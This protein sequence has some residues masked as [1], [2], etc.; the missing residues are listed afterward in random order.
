MNDK[1]RRTVLV[2]DDE[3]LVLKTFA[4]VFETSDIRVLSAASGEEALAI[5]LREPV[6]VV[7]SDHSMPGMSGVELLA[8]LKDH[9]PDTVRILMTGLTDHRMVVAAI[10]R[11]EA[12]RFVA[13]P[14]N[15]AELVA[16]ISE[17]LHHYEVLTSMRTGDEARYRSLAATIEL[18]DRYTRGHCDRV[19]DIADRIAEVAHVP[20]HIRDYIRHGSILHD[21]GKIGVPEH[22]L[23]FPGRLE[24]E[25]FELVKKHPTWGADIARKA[26]LPEPVINVILHHHEQF[27]GGGYPAGLAGEAI[28]LE[29]RIVAIADVFDALTSSRPYRPKM[30]VDEALA[31]MDTMTASHF[32]P[33]LMVAFR[34]VV[35]EPAFY[36]AAA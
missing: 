11:S 25:D 36:Q 31:L 20:E 3:V 35:S 34:T 30:P 5:A 9:S 13:K 1:L 12:W 2:V 27:D 19:A 22:I 8:V 16:M 7:V 24:A 18:K 28:P 21:C 10:N 32:D 29:A 6:G 4:R 33:T 23:N 17:A 26:Q 15:H 14:W